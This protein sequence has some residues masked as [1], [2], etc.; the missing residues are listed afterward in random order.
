MND[1]KSPWD[2]TDEEWGQFHDKKQAALDASPEYQNRI[3]NTKIMSSILVDMLYPTVPE[4]AF[5]PNPWDRDSHVFRALKFY[6]SV[7]HNKMSREI[8]A[9]GS[10]ADTL[11]IF[12]ERILDACIDARSPFKVGA[13]LY[14]YQQMCDGKFASDASLSKAQW[15]LTAAPLTTDESTV[16]KDGGSPDE[17]GKQ[18]KHYFA[19]AHYWAAFVVLSGTPLQYQDAAPLN[20]ICNIDSTEFLNLAAAFFDF[21]RR[22][23]VPF[24]RRKGQEIPYIKQGIAT[25]PDNLKEVPLMSI[26][27][28]PDLLA[29]YQWDMLQQYRTNFRPNRQSTNA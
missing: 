18:W 9:L 8:P 6:G 4:P 11:G 5:P 29:G 1:R 2:W 23:E 16:R 3:A 20:F 28:I 24:A 26:Q 22:V 12:R 19:V 13:S 15:L 7:Y 10:L 14:I 17:I 21:R 27:D 25:I